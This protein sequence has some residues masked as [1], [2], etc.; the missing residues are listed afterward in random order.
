MGI[1]IKH[2]TKFIP[3]TRVLEEI[4]R[5]KGTIFGI[6]FLKM[7]GQ[8]RKMAC[9]KSVKKG[10]KGTSNRNVLVEDRNYGYVRVF[11]INVMGFRRIN[12]NEVIEI[13]VRGVR[14][15]VSNY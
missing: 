8:I 4:R 15:I 6:S 9:R 1:I 5:A 10:V 13:K 3:P 11:D 2:A 14:S 12:I 7:N